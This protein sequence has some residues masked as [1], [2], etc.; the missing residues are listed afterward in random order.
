MKPG[1]FRNICLGRKEY[2]LSLTA[3]LPISYLEISTSKCYLLASLLQILS[4]LIKLSHLTCALSTTLNNSSVSTP[5][6]LSISLRRNQRT[7]ALMFLPIR[8][9]ALSTAI[10][11]HFALTANTTFHW[12]I[13]RTHTSTTQ[14]TTWKGP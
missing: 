8:C 5:P 10:P 7:H 13:C 3:G 6:V 11:R 12:S 4:Y 1:V 9:L 2:Q 14:M